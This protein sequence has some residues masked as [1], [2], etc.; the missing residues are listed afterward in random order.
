[1]RGLKRHLDNFFAETLVG[2]FKVEE[3]V[4]DVFFPPSVCGST[5][6]GSDWD[7]NMTDSGFL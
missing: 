5:L 3:P 6:I 4:L 2:K 1:M 7:D